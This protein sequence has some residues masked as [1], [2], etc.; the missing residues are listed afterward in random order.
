MILPTCRPQA[1]LAAGVDYLVTNDTRLL[2]LS[3]YE[4]LWVV[5]TA[6]D[7][8]LNAGLRAGYSHLNQRRL[9]TVYLPY[10]PLP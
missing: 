8:L 4:G 5:S 1:A 9:P 6:D 10:P 7:R 2:S 3:P